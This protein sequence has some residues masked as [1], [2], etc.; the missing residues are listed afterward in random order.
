MVWME[1]NPA[2]LPLEV[3]LLL[4]ELKLCSVKE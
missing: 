2:V 1:T 4:R 3:G